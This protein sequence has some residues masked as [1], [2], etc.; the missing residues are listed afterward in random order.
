[1]REFSIYNLFNTRHLNLQACSSVSAI[2]S[3]LST[4]NRLFAFQNL[5]HVRR[6]WFILES[7]SWSTV[8][9]GAQCLQQSCAGAN[10]TALLLAR[11]SIITW[12]FLSL[13]P[14]S[15][16]LQ[17]APSDKAAFHHS[18]NDLMPAVD[19]WGQQVLGWTPLTDNDY[20]CCFVGVLLR[21]R[22]GWINGA[23]SL[24]MSVRCLTLWELKM[25][26]C[27][28]LSKGSGPSAFEPKLKFS[29]GIRLHAGRTLLPRKLGT[30]RKYWCLSHQ[31][32]DA[33]TGMA[34]LAETD[35][36]EVV[37]NDWCSYR[38]FVATQ[39]YAP[40]PSNAC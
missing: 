39:R 33:Q 6:G 2:G 7:R 18:C 9:A 30:R 31:K 26:L 38:F 3:C 22:T 10:L 29:V 17:K 19:K 15:V 36:D 25:L 14:I 28:N 1:M 32:A 11:A 40:I 34:S 21:R 35:G 5:D 8:V 12:K 20:L 23:G 24:Y 37:T 27:E 13:Y 4:H 16:E